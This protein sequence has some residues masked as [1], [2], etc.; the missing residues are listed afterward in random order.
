LADFSDFIAVFSCAPHNY[1]AVQHDD[2]PRCATAFRGNTPRRFAD[3][4]RD[5]P[6]LACRSA[7]M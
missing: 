3:G 4:G 1:I 2:S 7:A 5:R 6:S